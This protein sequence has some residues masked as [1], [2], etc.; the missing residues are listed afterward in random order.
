MPKYNDNILNYYNDN[1]HVGSLNEKLN[2]V[3]TGLVGSPSCG[4]VMKLQIKVK[5]NKIVD[6]KIMVFGCGSAKASS[7]YLAEQ[8]IG[9]TVKEAMKIK[10]TDIANSLG[11]P[12]IKLHC[13]VL[14]EGAIKRA[15]EDFQKKNN[16][17]KDIEENET[18]RKK[19]ADSMKN[20]IIKGVKSKKE[21]IANADENKAKNENK[22][23]NINTNH[24]DDDY[25]CAKVNK[26]ACNKTKTKNSNSFSDEKNNKIANGEKNTDKNS[27]K[28]INK[29]EKN[30]S[31]SIT[32]KAIDFTKQHLN[33]IGKNVK[34]VCLSLEAGHCGLMYKVRYVKSD[35]NTA[36]YID[37]IKNGLHI[38]VAKKE[39]DVLNMTKIEYK[40]EGL[41]R[42]LIFKNPKESG[43]CKCGMN[44]FVKKQQDSNAND[45][46]KVNSKRKIN[47]VKSGTK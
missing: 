17:I 7:S 15:I 40:E 24:R 46:A 20:I 6:A 13:S 10:N 21:N 35:E 5:K 19:I 25:S 41:K 26:N 32:D 43:R 37:F 31:I 18:N 1:S 3:G 28:N 39:M 8:L 9:K 11:L 44:F 33:K 38:F 29:K 4:D 16:G 12:K 47:L 45:S 22:N 14:A 30:F 42:G 2:D 23:S 36:D 34:G 27:K